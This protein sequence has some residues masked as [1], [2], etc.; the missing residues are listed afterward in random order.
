MYS[1]QVN[2]IT[3]IEILNSLTF[4]FRESGK[5]SR[6]HDAWRVSRH[7]AAR[8]FSGTVPRDHA[9][10]HQGDPRRV[11]IVRGVRVREPLA[12]RQHDVIST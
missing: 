8:G 1:I 4:Y 10:L 6:G 7:R 3:K 5:G 2:R 11:H 12:R 9:Q